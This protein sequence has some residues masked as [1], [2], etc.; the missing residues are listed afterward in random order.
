MKTSRKI[1]LGTFAVLGIAFGAV[2]LAHEHGPMMMGHGHDGHAQ[3]EG[4]GHCHD[5]GPEARLDALKSELKLTAAQE[6][7]WQAFESAVQA[8]KDAHRGKHD[9]HDMAEGADPMQAR[10]EH[11]EQR[12]AG[13]KAV[14]QARADLYAVLTPEQKAVADRLMSGPRG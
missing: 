9:M 5:G 2:A 6:P 4:K 12:L 3:H 10:I 1:A 13:M 14:A 7:A 11:M 8:Q